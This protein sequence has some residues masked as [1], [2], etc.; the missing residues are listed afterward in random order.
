M[1]P[2]ATASLAGDSSDWTSCRQAA[3]IATAALKEKRGNEKHGGLE[4]PHGSRMV[5]ENQ[6]SRQDRASADVK[7]V[8]ALVKLA[9]R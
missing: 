8:V 1:I 5:P 2:A 3:R 9:S 6:E 7:I 4:G